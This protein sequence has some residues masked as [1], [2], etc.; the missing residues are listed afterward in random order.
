MICDTVKPALRDHYHERP[1]VLRDHICM[2]HGV[3][4][5]DRFY[6]NMCNTYS[7]ELG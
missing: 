5:Q 7:S 2:A 1:P 3:L 6:C 4:F